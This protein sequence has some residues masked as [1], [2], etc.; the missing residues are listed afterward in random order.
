MIWFLLFVL[1]L[2]FAFVVLFGAP[3]LPTQKAQ[4][5]AALNLLDL[6]KG[7]TLL[8]LGCGDGRVLRAAAKRGING[9]GYELN[10]VLVLA[11]KIYTYKYRHLVIIKWG[12]YW[13]TSWPEVDGVYIFLLDRYMSKLEKKLLQE[14]EQWHKKSK[15]KLASYTFKMPHK[16]PTKQQSGVFL[17]E[18]K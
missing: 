6:K 18:Y 9:V 8:E 12:N 10:P 16:K 4:I 17:Y 2:L 1:L 15:T 3:F 13:R 14:K 5:K 7:Q 11:A